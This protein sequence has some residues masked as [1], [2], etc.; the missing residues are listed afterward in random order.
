MDSSAVCGL[1]KGSSS[2]V[3]EKGF[4]SEHV[5][6]EMF[7]DIQMGPSNRQLVQSTVESRLEKTTSGHLGKEWGKPC[8]W[9]R[10]H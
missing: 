4:S 3:G 2:G 1:E 5:K 8:D 6:F 9:M 7:L 10:S